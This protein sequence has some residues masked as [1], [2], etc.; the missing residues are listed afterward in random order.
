[1]R[2]SSAYTDYFVIYYVGLLATIIGVIILFPSGIDNT[3]PWLYPITAGGILTFIL[4]MIMSRP[5]WI[6]F[7]NDGGGITVVKPSLIFPP[8]K[9]RY[10]IRCDEIEYFYVVTALILGHKKPDLFYVAE[11]N[12]TITI[13]DSRNKNHILAANTR[14]KENGE[15][16][17]KRFIETLR[18]VSAAC[19]N[20]IPLFVEYD[21]LSDIQITP[22]GDR[23]RWFSVGSTVDPDFYFHVIETR[24]K[25]KDGSPVNLDD[26]KIP[27]DVPHI[28]LKK[29]EKPEEK[30]REMKVKE[31]WG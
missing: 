9:V 23:K 28:D 14:F 10:F 16:E 31:L 4:G 13:V 8:L 21:I 20:S 6:D 26:F 12:D 27:D 29:D 19:E 3:D 15:N 18:E 22:E 11:V 5:Y 17:R 25:N 1:M 2:R 30:F 24:V 7:K